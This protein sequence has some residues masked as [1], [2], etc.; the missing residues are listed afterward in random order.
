MPSV[1]AVASVAVVVGLSIMGLVGL[2]FILN[3]LTNPETNHWPGD[4]QAHPD[5]GA[6]SAG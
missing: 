5:G 6:R 3:E 2:T 1:E 4:D